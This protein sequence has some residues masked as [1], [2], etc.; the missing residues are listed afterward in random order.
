MTPERFCSEQA[1]AAGLG[2]QADRL[3]PWL[4]R[5]DALAD[6][7]VDAFASLAPAA[8]P[9]VSRPAPFKVPR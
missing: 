5:Q 6:A 3:E 9:G 1:N 2:D 7:V 8:Y 4:L